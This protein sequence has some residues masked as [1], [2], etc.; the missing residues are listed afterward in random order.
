MGAEPERR[1][2][3]PNDPPGPTRRWALFGLGWVFVGLGAL[4]VALPVLPTTPFLILALWAFSA[5]SERFHAW[6]Y[7]HR[8]FGPPLRRWHRERTI[9][10]AVKAVAVASML[11]SLAWLGFAVRP[12]A[13]V[14][15]GAIVLV[16]AGTVFLARVPSRRE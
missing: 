16:A 14:L 4:G 6:L 13:P 9:P 12:P 11:G 8:L 1:P 2:A 15:G 3:E 7:H 10:R 5:S